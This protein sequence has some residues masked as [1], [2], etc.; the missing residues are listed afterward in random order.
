MLNVEHEDTRSAID[1]IESCYRIIDCSQSFSHGNES[2]LISNG[3]AQFLLCSVDIFCLT[4]N[5]VGVAI[6]TL[7]LCIMRTDIHSEAVAPEVNIARFCLFVGKNLPDNIGNLF[8]VMCLA[9]CFG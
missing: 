7:H 2:L 4:Y 5:S 6:F 1:K 3:F 9:R 8:L